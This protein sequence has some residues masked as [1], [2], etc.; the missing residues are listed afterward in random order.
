M[1][2]VCDEDPISCLKYGV[3][4][5]FVSGCKQNKNK[6]YKAGTQYKFGL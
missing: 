2:M 6:L 4:V 1:I 5:V 3:F